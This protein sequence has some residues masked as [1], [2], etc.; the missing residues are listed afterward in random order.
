MNKKQMTDIVEQFSRN[1]EP[2]EGQVKVI[3]VPDS[4]TVYVEQ[5]GDYGR[6]INL[7]EYKVDGKIYWAGF[8]W[9]SGT[10][11]VSQASQS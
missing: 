6:S 1:S 4:K 2:A 3:R 8:S 9:L 10:V 11:F 5:I 7:S